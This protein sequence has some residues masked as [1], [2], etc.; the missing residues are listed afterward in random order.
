LP[1]SRRSLAVAA[2]ARIVV[3]VNHL[4]QAQKEGVYAAIGFLRRRIEGRTA[5]SIIPALAPRHD[6]GFEGF[7]DLV[8]YVLIVILPGR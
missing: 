5:A 8:G 3:A 6:T 1:A 2:P 7:N 4:Y